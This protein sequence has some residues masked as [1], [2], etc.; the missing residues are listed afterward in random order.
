MR[1]RGVCQLCGKRADYS[2]WKDG[3]WHFYEIKIIHRDEYHICFDIDH[4]APICQGGKTHKDNLRL[5]CQKCNRSKGSK[6]RK[7]GMA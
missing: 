4:I 3:Y 6:E 2:K 5:L 1:D 7:N